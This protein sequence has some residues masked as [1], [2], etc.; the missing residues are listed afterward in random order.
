M[1]IVAHAQHQHIDVCQL[2]DGGIGQLGGLLMAAS[3]LIEAE[4]ARLGSRPAQ[5]MT[6]HQGFVAGRMID[7]HPA[8]VG[9]AHQHLRPGQRLLRQ[10]LEE[11]HRA[12]PA[13]HHQGRLATLG[14][15]LAQCSGNALRQCLGQLPGIAV[16]AT[17]DARRQ[18]QLRDRHTSSSRRE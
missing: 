9:Q 8:L 16:H 17:V 15:R 3:D 6:A 14:K 13:G 2:G 11:R 10:R 1:A 7:R 4:K 5:Q 12:A 18:R